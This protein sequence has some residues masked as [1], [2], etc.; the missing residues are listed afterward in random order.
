MFGSNGFKYGFIVFAWY[1][2]TEGGVEYFDRI[3]DMPIDGLFV[4]D[5]YGCGCDGWYIDSI[6]D[7]LVFIIDDII[8]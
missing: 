1:K 8:K 6:R 4:F 7:F 3:G 2:F 5:I